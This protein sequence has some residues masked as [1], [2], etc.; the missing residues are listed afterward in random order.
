MK[1]HA[2]WSRIWPRRL[3]N[4]KY[5]ASAFL[6]CFMMETLVRGESAASFTCSYSILGAQEK[7]ENSPVYATY[8]LMPVTRVCVC[9]WV[10][11]IIC[12]HWSK[13]PYITHSLL[14]EALECRALFGSVKRW[15][16]YS[17]AVSFSSFSLYHFVFYRNSLVENEENGPPLPPP[18]SLIKGLF[19]ALA[20]LPWA[21]CQAMSNDHANMCFYEFSRIFFSFLS[22]VLDVV[23]FLS[24]VMCLFCTGSSPDWPVFKQYKARWKPG[25]YLK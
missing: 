13:C 12:Q 24:P 17:C 11:R 18:S 14:A 7:Q 2:E 22:V 20:W 25:N 15:L 1:Q 16:V 23:N 8:L 21:W 6:P 9:V 19:N 4:I 10:S 3:I 5:A